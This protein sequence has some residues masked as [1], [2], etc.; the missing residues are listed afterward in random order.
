MEEIPNN[1]WIRCNPRL[2]SERGENS[3]EL[4]WKKGFFTNR[5]SSGLLEKMD[6]WG[7]NMICI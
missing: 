3:R 7:L 1:D 2:T 4:L 6:V 5:T